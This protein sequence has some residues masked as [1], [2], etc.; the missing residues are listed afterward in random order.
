M[1]TEATPTAADE[2]PSPSPPRRTKPTRRAHVDGRDWI[3]E[4]DHL[5][6]SRLRLAAGKLV[7]AAKTADDDE[8]APKDGPQDEGSLARSPSTRCRVPPPQRLTEP[9]R[10]THHEP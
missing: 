4:F 6:R 8:A 10:N 3:I 1:Q 5:D 2:D 9:E 7:R